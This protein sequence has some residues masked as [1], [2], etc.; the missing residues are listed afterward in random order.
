MRRFVS[1]VSLGICALTAT[2]LRAQSNQTINAAGDPK[3]WQSA[4]H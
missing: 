1:A 2:P 4:K 3:F